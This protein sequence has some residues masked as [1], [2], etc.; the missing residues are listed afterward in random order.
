MKLLIFTPVVK[1]SAIGRVAYLV[2]NALISLGHQVV[3][4]QTEDAL[5]DFKTAH[6]FKAEIIA[7]RD[8][9][10]IEAEA[11]RSDAI[12]YKAGDNYNFHR[13]ILEWLPRL[14]G[15]VSL[16][17]FFLGSL[18]WS[19][20]V[21]NRKQAET[22]LEAWYGTEIA[23]SFFNY[24]DS[25]SF[26]EGTC[27]AS[28]MTEWIC[29]MATG[30]IT[31]SNWGI[32]RVLQACSGPVQVVPLAYNA[33]HS[34]KDYFTANKSSS[35]NILTV[36]HMN[37]NK[38]VESVIRAIGGSD[39]L[40]EH[41]MY[42]LVGQIQPEYAT[43]ITELAKR[44]KV[45]LEISGVVDDATLLQAFKKADI[46]SCLRWP[47]LEA[48]SASTIEAMLYGKPT[49]VTDTGFY[50]ELPGDCVIKVNPDDEI[51]SIKDAL[52]LLYNDATLRH[53]MGKLSKKW[54][55]ETF[56]ADNYAHRLIDIVISTYKDKPIFEAVN[57]NV[58]ILKGW[59][60]ISSV[61]NLADT[62]QPLLIFN[63]LVASPILS[64]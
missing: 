3:V 19:W 60:A 22:I 64:K 5:P 25:K 52:E 55:K 48:A 27:Q 7:W 57:A 28:P 12:I 41:V 1:A 51:E 31:H 9:Q 24:S 53:S 36:G 42:H 6:P 20:S 61:I 49:I 33:P 38:R 34:S 8:V 59:G 18:F 44:L 21:N 13:G 54:A 4:V 14:P 26:I 11:V 40:C 16:H 56:T 43:E 10:R 2:T 23:D 30:V 29:A 32:N 46:V 62:T 39:L 17:D 50:S 35:F 37:P 63:G 15:I 45:N 47:S 58:D